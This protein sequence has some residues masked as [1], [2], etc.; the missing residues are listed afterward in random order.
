[1]ANHTKM[2]VTDLDDTLLRNDKTIS[3]FTVQTLIKCQAAGIKIAYATAR[4]AQAS[5]KYLDRFTP[6]IFI[7]YGGALVMTGNEIIFR[8]DIS[9]DVADKLIKMC[10][11]E[12]AVIGIHAINEAIALSSYPEPDMRHYRL[13]DFSSDYGKSYLKI[14]LSASDQTTTTYIK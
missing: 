11:S 6:D 9:A 8:F 5:M 10:L 4:S 1:M 13:T 14:S 12:P 2:I 3:D 7:G